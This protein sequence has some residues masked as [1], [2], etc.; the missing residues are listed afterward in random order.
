MAEAGSW[1]AWP[2]TD[3]LR[4]AIKA[5]PKDVLRR[6]GVDIPDEMQV[7]VVESTPDTLYI[8]LP[9]KA[10]GELSNAELEGVAGGTDDFLP[11]SGPA[12]Y[13]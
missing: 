11:W 1:R 8:A 13:Q 5:D 7:K 6:E 3:A 9:P 2:A 12:K 4:E 10:E